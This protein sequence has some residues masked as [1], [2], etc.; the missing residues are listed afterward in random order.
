MSKHGAISEPVF[1]AIFEISRESV[2]GSVSWMC[3][4]RCSCPAGSF[5]E[6]TGKLEGAED[7]PCHVR[8]Q[9]LMSADTA[10]DEFVEQ[11]ART[12]GAPDSDCFPREGTLSAPDTCIKWCHG[13]IL[14]FNRIYGRIRIQTNPYPTTRSSGGGGGGQTPVFQHYLQAVEKWT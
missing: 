14:K 10:F 11:R 3:Q 4:T 6:R 13:D 12:A 8:K 1:S 9:Y 7:Q 2:R 5:S